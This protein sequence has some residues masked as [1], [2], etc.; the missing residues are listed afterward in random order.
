MGLIEIFVAV[1]MYSDTLNKKMTCH[2]GNSV[3]IKTE[4]IEKFYPD[5]GDHYI[6]DVCFVHHK[7]G[8]RTLMY[9]NCT[10]FKERLDKTNDR[11]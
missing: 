9:E 6:G 10:Q 4:S 11:Q 7:D 1:C 8:Y 5:P 2:K 3:W